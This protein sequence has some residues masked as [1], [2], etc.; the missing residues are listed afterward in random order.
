VHA[1]VQHEQ[2]IPPADLLGELLGE[3]PAVQRVQPDRGGDR[4]CHG[5]RLRDPRQRD[6]ADAVLEPMR[7]QRGHGQCEPG[8][9]H[10][11]G[12]AQGEQPGGPL[13]DQ[14]GGLLDVSR[15][16][17]QLVRRDRRQPQYGAGGVGVAAG[18]GRQLGAIRRPEP[19]R[20]A[21]QPQRVRPGRTTA[22]PL[23]RRDRVD[24]EA[25]QLRQLL[26]GQSGVSPVPSEQVTEASALRVVRAA[27]R[28][29]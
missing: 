25:G 18:G 13:A 20:V 9:A 1:V 23:Q 14:P 28:P 27:A 5:G 24:A 12:T 22:S 2:Q 10:S 29:V 6:P 16:A 8:L 19:Q 11:R 7:D 26:L 4:R 17:D 21:Q 15:P 3:P